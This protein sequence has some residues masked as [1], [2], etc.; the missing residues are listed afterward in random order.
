M[1]GA[2]RPNAY[3]TLRSVARDHGPSIAAIVLTPPTADCGRPATATGF[4][5]TKRFYAQLQYTR[6]APHGSVRLAVR[7]RL[8]SGL[9]AIAFR[10]PAAGRRVVLLN[11]SG[12]DRR[13]SLD[14]GA[15]SGRLEAR[16][17]SASEGFAR[18]VLGRYRG[19][20]TLVEAPAMSLTTFFLAR[21]AG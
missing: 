6:A 18:L 13:V 17:T 16:R 8:P 19:R 20:P 11:E 15:R 5:L 3:L 14:L 2:A 7:Q 21:L 1:S 4:V 9:K 12:T 10:A